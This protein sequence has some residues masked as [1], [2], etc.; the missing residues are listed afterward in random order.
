MWADGWGWAW[1]GL[2]SGLVG[3]VLLAVVVLA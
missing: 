2:V 3:L 1:V